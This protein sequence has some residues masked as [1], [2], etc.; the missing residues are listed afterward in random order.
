MFD[1][2]S[3]KFPYPENTDQHYIILKKDDGQVFDENYPYVDESF[4]MRF[5]Q[6]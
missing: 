5:K 3:T 2:K 4:S 1:P 6:F